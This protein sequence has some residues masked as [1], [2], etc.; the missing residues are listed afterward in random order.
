MKMYCDIG[1]ALLV[2]KTKTLATQIAPGEE[3]EFSDDDRPADPYL[4]L[5]EETLR[6]RCP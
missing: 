2:A 4:I 1:S 3:D 6:E 5:I